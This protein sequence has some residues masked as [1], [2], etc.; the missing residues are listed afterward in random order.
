MAVRHTRKLQIERLFVWAGDDGDDWGHVGRRI[1]VGDGRRDSVPMKD[2]PSPV[3]SA[4]LGGGLPDVQW[5]HRRKPRGVD[6]A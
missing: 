2:E 6:L 1:A 4:F 5:P 3:K